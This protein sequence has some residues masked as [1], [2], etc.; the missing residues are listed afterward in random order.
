MWQEVLRIAGTTGQNKV[1]NW[2]WAPLTIRRQQFP[3]HLWIQCKFRRRQFAL[4]C[5]SGRLVCCAD[6]PKVLMGSGSL[7]WLWAEWK[8]VTI[9]SGTSY[10]HW[11]RH[12]LYS[13]RDPKEVRFWF[14]VN[15][16]H[17]AEG[18]DRCPLRSL[19]ILPFK[20]SKTQ[21]WPSGVERAG[22][23]LSYW[24]SFNPH[25]DK[26]L[27]ATSLPSVLQLFSTAAYIFFLT[28]ILW[29]CTNRCSTQPRKPGRILWQS[30]AAV[31][32]DTGEEQGERQ[33]EG[34]I[35]KA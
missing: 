26:S 24:C 15:F 20:D 34:K 32:L 18:W 28:S 22:R 11:K 7:A 21:S 3:V 12:P 14:Y 23:H 13:Q 17:K 35:Q 1:S 30:E 25:F 2:A 8:N 31:Y 5:L 6:N 27:S 29:N 19:A 9:K 4:A 10:S 33:K 16:V